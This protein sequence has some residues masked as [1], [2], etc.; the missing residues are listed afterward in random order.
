MTGLAE[1]AE[2]AGV[3]TSTVSRVLNRRGGVNDNTRARVLAVV[4]Q[5]PYSRRGLGAMHRTGVIGL[6]VPDLSNP[7]FPAFAEELE[8][9]LAQAGYSALLCN[10]RPAGFREEEYTRM[11]LDRGVEGMVFVCPDQAD[12]TASRARYRQ[13]RDRGV[14]MV[15]INSGAVSTEVPEITVDQQAAGYTATRHLLDLGHERIGFVSGPANA[16]MSRL[17]QIGWTAAL[18]ETGHPADAALVAHGPFGPEGGALAMSQLLETARP[19]GVICSSDLMAMG[20][21]QEAARR[22]LTVPRDLSVI[23]FDD[24]SLAAYWSPPLTTLAQPIPAMAA[25]AIDELVAGLVPET[26]AG[27]SPASRVF[28]AQLVV[29]ESSAPPG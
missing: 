15:F 27:H 21:S 23:G 9:G 13:L 8:T 22:G 18:E 29:R 28:R 17:L 5:R 16:L 7:V 4:A 25:A 19:T 12:S 10:T 20:A 2:A 14:Y 24:I 26:R 11:L 3:S 1:I 6:L